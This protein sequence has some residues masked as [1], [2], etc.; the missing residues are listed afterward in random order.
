[1]LVVILD[2]ARKTA[3][4]AALKRNLTTDLQ[5]RGRRKI[6]FP[7]GSTKARLYTNGAGRLW[8][9]FREPTEVRGV[10][11][12]WNAFGAYEPN[13]PA[14]S[15]SVEIN[16]ATEADDAG[17]AGFFAEDA[18]TGAL[19]LMHSGRVGGGRPGISK[20]AFLVWSKAKL[21]DVSDGDGG[22]RSGI[23][24]AK[25]D[26]RYL[27]DNIW[28]FATSVQ[29]FKDEV[30]KGTFQ[31]A[32]IELRIEKFNQYSQEFAG[33]KRG[34]RSEVLEY[35]SYHGAIVQSLYLERSATLLPGEKIFNTKL[36][37][38]IVDRDG[39]LS[40]IYEVKTDTRR[41][42]LYTA[43]GQILTHSIS[44]PMDVARFL[45]IPV[46]EPLP[47]DLE[48]AITSLGIKL[49]RFRLRKRAG[50]CVVELT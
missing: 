48:R 28:Q 8:A 1:M 39:L 17:V 25:L 34:V 32:E 12:Y 5:D 24:I 7:G 31:R 2:R 45:V 50:S 13:R 18:Q 16:I 41:Q 35:M 4:Q 10:P 9:A 22:T 3:A 43:V 38:L 15:I 6:G 44:G 30:R 19:F 40:E 42:M 47:P 11:R 23:V 37:D 14:Q 27:V 33:K 20:S 46:D 49:R 26:D 36:I 21:I 29:N